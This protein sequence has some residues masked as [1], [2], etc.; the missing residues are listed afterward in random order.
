MKILICDDEVAIVNILEEL[1]SDFHDVTITSSPTIATSLIAKEK[2]DVI[3]TDYNMPVMNGKELADLA[4]NEHGMDA[5]ILT[6]DTEVD[7]TLEHIR[8]IYK[9]V[10]FKRLL[11]ILEEYEESRSDCSESVVNEDE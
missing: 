9:P 1:L 2:F 11:S 6:G 8:T 5:I 7:F 3:V 4:I 10:N